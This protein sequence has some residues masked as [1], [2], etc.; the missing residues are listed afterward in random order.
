MLNDQKVLKYVKDDLAFPFMHL[1]LTDEEILDYVKHYTLHEFS[2]YVPY[3]KK[4]YLDLNSDQ[5]KVPERGNEFYIYDDE[6]L[7]IMNVKDIY[8]DESDY[9]IHGHPP[10]GPMTYNEIPEWMLATE[11]AMTTKMYSSFDKTFEFK[12][13]NVIRISPIVSNTRGVTVEY[14]TIQPSDFRGIPNQHHRL[15][16]RLAAADIKLMIG[17]IRKRYGDG[18]LTTPFG[19]VNL[20]TDIFDEGQEQRREIIEKLENTLIP[21]IVMDRG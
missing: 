13:P 16:C 15:F 20:G 14:E 7:E 2:E 9:Y 10:L 8:P 12:H 19:E 21:N 4:S 1:E 6:G 3:V 11:Q 5:N 17:R 18:R